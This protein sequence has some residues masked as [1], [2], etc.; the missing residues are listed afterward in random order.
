MG[1]AK[2]NPSVLFV[3]GR[4]K[5]L[6]VTGMNQ[7]SPPALR[8]QTAEEVALKERIQKEAEQQVLAE[9][10]DAKSDA[11]GTS[12]GGAVLQTVGGFLGGWGRT[13]G[14]ISN[15]A[16][17]D[18]SRQRLAQAEERVKEIVQEKTTELEQKLAENNRKQEFEADEFGYQY[19]AKAGFEAE[20]CIRVMDVLGRTSGAEFDTTHP[21][22]PKRIEQ[23]RS[24][25]NQYPPA[26]LA[27]EGES[28]IKSTQPLTY[29]LSK[30]GQSLRIN[31]R[32][33][34]SAADDIDRRFSQ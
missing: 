7:R 5:E 23:L 11:T 28:L 21:A 17:Q 2:R 12:I 15:S 13:A 3:A 32:R 1:G 4:P 18:A 20:G 27:Q 14:N 29:S 31:S 10:E 30:D 33:G 9:I 22:I 19:I 8:A 6:F 16:L 26:T 24:L 34:G 25:M